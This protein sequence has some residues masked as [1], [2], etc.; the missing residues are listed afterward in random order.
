MLIEDWKNQGKYFTYKNKYKIFYQESGH[1]DPLLLLH[2]FPTASWDWNKLWGS[3]QK[4]YHLLAPDFIGFGY[5]DKPKNYEYSI[6]DQADVI[7]HFLENINVQSAHILAHDYGDTVLQELLARNIDRNEA[8]ENGFKIKSIA[9]LNGGLFP[10][11]HQARPI[12]KLLISPIGSLLV[13]FLNKKSLRRSFNNIFG[14]NTQPTDQE[15][16][17]FYSLV[18][19]KN[20]KLIFHKLIRYMN[21]RRKYRERWVAALQNSPAPIRV[22]DGAI[23]PVSGKHMTDRF[24]SLITDPDIILLDEIG[25]YPQTEAPA[26]VL[27]YYYEFR[28]KHS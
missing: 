12:Q 13:H 20:G 11:T 6:H 21:D 25:H 9:L 22:I 10:E 23:D 26:E 16:D 5:S 7:E 2:G 28:E 3:L 8:G 24:R 4:K 19:Y 14:K 18:D 27:K 15:I 17:E 1:G